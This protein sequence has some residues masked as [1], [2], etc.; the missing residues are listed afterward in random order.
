MFAGMKGTG[1]FLGISVEEGLA[2]LTAVPSCVVLTCI[3]HT[4]T[5]IARCQT[6]G[7]VKVT[8]AGMPM[9]FALWSRT[10]KEDM[11]CTKPWQVWPGRVGCGTSPGS[12]G[13]AQ[14]L[15]HAMGGPGTDPGSTHSELY[16]DGRHKGH[17]PGRKEGKESLPQRPSLST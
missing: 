7:H 15:L 11:E 4:S 13:G 1:I 6:Q 17:A 3:A 5:R 16:G 2:E 8:T 12:H 9:A 14:A 10:R